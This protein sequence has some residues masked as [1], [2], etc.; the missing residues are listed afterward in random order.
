[1]PEG[2]RLVIETQQVLVNGDYRRAHP[3]AKPGRYVLLTVSD[4]GIGMPPD[5]AERAG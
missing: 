2:G 3:W 5:V 4:S 1:M